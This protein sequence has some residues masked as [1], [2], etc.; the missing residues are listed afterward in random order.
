MRA[1]IYTRVSQDPT[2]ELRSIE[3]QEDECRAVCRREGWEVVRVF[4]DNDR[5]ASRHSRKERPEYLALRPFL[6]G[7][8]ADVLVMWEGSRAQRDIAAYASLRDLCAERGILYN[9]SGRTYDLTRT[10]DRFSTGL[11]ALLAER[12]SDVISDR[13][14]SDV[15]RNAVA[16]RPHGKLAYGY[17]REYSERGTFVRQYVKEEEAA[18][19]RECGRR[20]LAGDSLYG[21]AQDLN[22]RGIA[23]PQGGRWIPTQIKRLVTNPRYIGQRVYRGAV[24]GDA[25]W[26]AILDEST[27]LDCKARLEDPRRS[28]VRDLS[29]KYLLSG[30]ARCGVCAEKMRVIKNRGYYAYSCFG[31]FCTAVKVEALEEYVV[32]VIIAR[33]SQPDFLTALGAAQGE[34]G[35]APMDEARTLRERLDGFYAA[36]AAGELTPAGLAAVEARLL[37][38]IE[39][40]Q[41]REQAAR[42]P[43]V[44][45]EVTGPDIA[46]RWETFSVGVRR[47]VIDSLMSI[48]V[49]RTVRGSRFKPER[50]QIEWKT[51]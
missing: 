13:V 26:P 19:V 36:S 44:L 39:Q 9:Y 46:Q 7:G 17:A 24:I 45:R 42:I 29:L 47:E 25:V 5:G 2:K 16:G 41:E 1:V 28:T 37:V 15:R 27:F 38:Q 32:A 35:A 11:D 18:I 30:T 23:A 8:G 21:I 4:T 3:K 14:K 34:G 12:E 43:A 51:I 31:N 50:V 22:A 48:T 10:D 6:A 20:V 49:N 33:L 40:A